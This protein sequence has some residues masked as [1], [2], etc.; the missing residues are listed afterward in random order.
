MLSMEII[1]MTSHLRD[2]AFDEY[3]R[4]GH[5]WPSHKLTH[6]WF[7]EVSPSN[8]KNFFHPTRL[9]LG[10]IWTIILH[11]QVS[12]F[13]LSSSNLMLKIC[14]IVKILQVHAR[15]FFFYWKILSQPFHIFSWLLPPQHQKPPTWYDY[16]CLSKTH[17]HSSYSHKLLLSNTTNVTKDHK[18]QICCSLGA[19][20]LFFF[21]FRANWKMLMCTRQ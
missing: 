19:I 12:E 1:S 21:Y 10:L 16:Y 15:L 8:T 17:L 14:K 20:F 18:W 11:F 5:L 13:F 7:I 3:A 2:K 4:N 6:L 9:T